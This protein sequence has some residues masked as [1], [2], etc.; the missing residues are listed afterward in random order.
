MACSRPI[1]LCTLVLEGHDRGKDRFD[2]RS[3]AQASCLWMEKWVSYFFCTRVEWKRERFVEELPLALFAKLGVN[4]SGTVTLRGF[5]ECGRRWGWS[6]E[7]THEQKGRVE[8]TE[9]ERETGAWLREGV[10]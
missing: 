5:E 2:F 1:R 8:R 4:Y 9:K 3:P 7:F 6:D 10:L